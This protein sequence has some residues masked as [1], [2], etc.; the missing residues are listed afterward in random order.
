ML[1]SGGQCVSGM[2]ML[3]EGP[4]ILIVEADLACRSRLDAVFEAYGF[5]VTTVDSAIGAAGLVAD[6]Q[7]DVIL[8]DVALPYRSGANW[9]SKLKLDPRTASI[10]VVM[11]SSLP[12][13]LPIARRNLAFA[14]I[15]KP[16]DTKAL[17]HTVQAACTHRQRRPL[18]IGSASSQPLGLL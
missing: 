4:R 8:L 7:P 18:T 11:L 1:R 3:Q 10:P 2:T 12:E 13:I 9:L 6:L 15:R 17:V 16:F 14:V 5:D